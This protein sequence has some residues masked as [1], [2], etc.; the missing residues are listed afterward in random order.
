M[1]ACLPVAAVILAAGAATRM[2]KLKQLLPYR[3]RTLIQN[4][5][6]QA[7]QADFD[8][9]LVVVGAESAA[10]RSVLAS[11]KVAIIENSYWQTGM[12]SSVS[13]G[14]RWLRNEETEAAAVAI[15]LGDQPLV[16]AEHLANMR[17]RLHRGPADAIAAEYG[18]TLGVPALFRRKVF[19]ALSELPAMAGA[20]HLLR[21]PGLNVEPFPLPEAAF[22]VDTPADYDSLEA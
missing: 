14:V 4:A 7:I 9:V 1:A 5:V 18:G 19:S 10:V 16:K 15:L 12:G 21:H 17:T 20:R 6:D 22:D 11:H 3:G 8:P 13:A 2:G